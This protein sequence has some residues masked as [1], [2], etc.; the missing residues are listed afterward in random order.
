MGD[1]LC[2]LML[3]DGVVVAVLVWCAA[4]WYL[5]D[6]D[7]MIGLGSGHPLPQAQPDPQSPPG[8]MTPQATRPDF[9][10]VWERNFSE[11]QE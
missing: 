10:V 2:Q 1:R 9:L 11:A 8:S 3:E 6:R 4:A 7:A 5:K